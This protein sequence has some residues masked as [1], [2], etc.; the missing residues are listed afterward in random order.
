MVSGLWNQTPYQTL[1]LRSEE[2]EKGTM[3]SR[4]LTVQAVRHGPSQV[5]VTSAMMS[6]R[7]VAARATDLRAPVGWTRGLNCFSC[8]QQSWHVFQ[9]RY[10]NW[11]AFNQHT[12]LLAALQS[13]VRSHWCSLPVL[14][15]QTSTAFFTLPKLCSHQLNQEG[16]FPKVWGYFGGVF[17]CVYGMWD[18]R[19]P[20]RDQTHASWGGR[21][22]S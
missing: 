22:E 9:R 2:P 11:S 15:A 17:W 3:P 13:L 14:M 20:T 10:L 6:Y 21:A 12:G 5:R 1:A 7:R 19:S 18:L 4:S 16:L 8:S